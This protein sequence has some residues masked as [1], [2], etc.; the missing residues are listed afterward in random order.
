MSV[1]EDDFGDMDIGEDGVDE[2]DVKSTG[3]E[4]TGAESAVVEEQVPIKKVKSKRGR[5]AKAKTKATRR[6]GAVSKRKSIAGK[7]KYRSKPG[8]AAVREIKALQKDS[9]RL[10]IP[11]SAFSRLCREVT[12]DVQDNDPSSIARFRKDALSTLHLA[13][14]AFITEVFEKSIKVTVRN[15]RQTLL[16]RDMQTVQEVQ[17]GGLPSTQD[18]RA[19]MKEMHK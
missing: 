2:E 8:K 12:G 13:A 5:P 11:K 14:E 19:A 7:R 3:A 15:K 10:I 18:V 9:V 17:M 4:S 1:V 6:K 16:P